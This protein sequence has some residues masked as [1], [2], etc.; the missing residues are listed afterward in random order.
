MNNNEE[1]ESE[2]IPK[3][4]LLV[5]NKNAAKGLKGTVSF[6]LNATENFTIST[7]VDFIDGETDHG[8][9]LIWGFKD[10]HNYNYFVIGANRMYTIGGKAGGRKFQI[11]TWKKNAAINQ[12]KASN[13]LTIRRDGNKLHFDIN[14]SNVY[15]CDFRAFSGNNV[16]FFILDGKQ[17]VLF[18]NLLVVQPVANK[19]DV[20]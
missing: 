16:G 20:E 17:E 11:I 10:V 13:K 14:E 18:K 6:S 19:P 9:G 15:S 1:F 4:G 7:T 8:H 12:D 5:K 3:K 2:I